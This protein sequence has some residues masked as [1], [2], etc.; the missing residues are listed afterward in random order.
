M[1]ITATA[2]G[3]AKRD[4]IPAGNYVA[5]CYSMIHIGTII[6][7]IMG[8]SKR[9]NKCR[10]TWELPQELRVF[11]EKKGEQPMVISKEYTLSMHEKSNLRR[12]LE[13]WR[14]KA[15]TDEQAAKFDITKLLGVP[16][17]LNIIHRQTKTGNEYAAISNISALPKGL[18]CPG[19]FNETFEFNFEEKFNEDVLN[20]F[21]DFIKDKIKQSEE[22]RR[23][24]MPIIDVTT[25]ETVL[26]EEPN[27]DLPF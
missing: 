25:D 9:L 1:S 4:L 3:S 24:K 14:G 23:L 7:E 27:N 21:P 11:D 17:M 26:E 22:Y 12:D 20:S 16:C 5:R 15:F 19:Q 8:E 10:I 2:S 18:T 13:S 6:E